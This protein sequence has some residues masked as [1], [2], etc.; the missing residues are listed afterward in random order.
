MLFIGFF[1]TLLQIIAQW[2]FIGLQSLVFLVSSI[3]IVIAFTLNR[4][5]MFSL[6]KRIFIFTIYSLGLYTTTLLGGAGLYHLGVFSTFTFGLILFDVRTEKFEILL[7]IPFMFAILIIGE[8][9]LFNAPDFSEHESIELA[10]ITS[11]ISLVTVNSILTIFIIRLNHKTQDEL[12]ELIKDKNRLLVEVNS[13]KEELKNSKEK[14][15]E[16]VIE[17]TT[18]ILEQKN[19]LI[20]Q[21][22]E[23]EV[24]LKEV[25]HRVKNNLQII[26]SLLN[27]QSTKFDDQKSLEAIQETRGR[28][29]SM[30]L[31]HTKMYQ[32][33]NLK[34]I[35]VYDYCDQLIKDTRGLFGSNKIDYTLEIP[36]DLKFDMERAIPLGLI[37]NEI[38]TNFFKHVVSIN[39]QSSRFIIKM[40]ESSGDYYTI[41]YSDNGHGFPEPLSIER[42]KTLGMQLIDSLVGQLEGE[43]SHSNDQGAIYKFT[44]KK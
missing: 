9:G 12:S 31:A 8:L 37:F 24:L 32:S 29:L 34:E 22:E 1:A 27:L 23:K 42:Y 18:E 38:I 10:R 19:I 13:N 3:S 25:H 4:K 36:T 39:S 21:N 30:A 28:V 14:L 20:R 7:G 15:E 16:T 2:D 33:S 26:V 17:R 6:S 40:V 43:F 44:V 41:T 11:I 5:G 35:C